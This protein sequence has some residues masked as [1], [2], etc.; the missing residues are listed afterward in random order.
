M[1]KPKICGGCGGTQFDSSGDGSTVC[2]ACGD[3][4]DSSNIVSEIQF[5]ESSGVMGT[6]V[7]ASGSTRSYKNLGRDSRELSIENAR[8]RLFQ[9]A[10]H[11]NL[12]QHHVDMAQRLYALA[13]EHH[14]TKGR[15]TQNIA[16]TCLYIVC[17]REGTPQTIQTN[18]FVLAQTFINFCKILNFQL[19]I[20]DPSL[21]I[22]RFANSLEFEE[23]TQEVAATALK[24]V[25]RMKRDW[26][27][28][29]RRP[30]GICGAALF[31]AAK[32]HG[33]KR[34]TK[35]IVK[36]VKI[37]EDTLVKRLKEFQKTPSAN[38]KV[39]E[40]DVLEIETECD[41]PSF[42]KIRR[43][44]LRTQRKLLDAAKRKHELLHGESMDDD[45][46]E[47]DDQEI[48]TK[49]EGKKRKKKQS[50]KKLKKKKK[51]K[52]E[53]EDEEIEEINDDNVN[54]EQGKEKNVNKIEEEEEEMDPSVKE[55]MEEIGKLISE[56]ENL[57]EKGINK[58]KAAGR[59]PPK[60]RRP[61]KKPETAEEA[62]AEALKR[63]AKQDRIMNL[64]KNILVNTEGDI[65]DEPPSTPMTSTTTTST[66]GRPGAKPPSKLAADT[67]DEEEDDDDKPSGSAKTLTY[68]CFGSGF[69]QPLVPGCLPKSLKTL[70]I[71]SS[72]N[73]PIEI[74]VL[75]ESLTDVTFGSEFDQPLLPMVLPDNLTHLVLKE[76]YNQTLHRGCLPSGLLHLVIGATYC[77][78]LDQGVLPPTLTYLDLGSEFNH[79]LPP[80]VLP[81][82]LVS[83]KLSQQ[84]SCPLEVG[85]L[86]PKLHSLSI[87]GYKKKL[88]SDIFPM[89]LRELKLES[90]FNENLVLPPTI[91][92]LEKIFDFKKS[93]AKLLVPANCSHLTV[94]N[95]FS[96]IQYIPKGVL[97][98]RLSHLDIRNPDL[99]QNILPPS[100]KSLNISVYQIIR[101]GVLP[102]SI[103]SLKLSMQE[104]FQVLVPGS[105]PGSLTRLRF[106]DSFNHSPAI[107]VLPAN[108]TK[109]AFGNSY[110]QPIHPG[111]LPPNLVTLK[112]GYSMDQPLINLPNSLEYL[113]LGECYQQEIDVKLLPTTL[114]LV[115]FSITYS[116]KER[117]RQCLL[118]NMTKLLE[119]NIRVKIIPMS[120]RGPR[121]RNV[122]S[123]QSDSMFKSE[124]Q[125]IL[126]R[127]NDRTLACTFSDDV[128]VFLETTKLG[129]FIKK[130]ARKV[131]LT[132]PG[133]PK[134][135]IWATSSF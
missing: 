65:K 29:G 33:F 37:G 31:I 6:F 127:V 74:G 52:E 36:V 64:F 132:L 71:G 103:T 69:N 123:Q 85:S 60:K 133:M 48:D 38:L 104:E 66:G 12:K 34:T 73:H 14:F 53:D 76:K 42:T 47:D 130:R 61:S 82:S 79:P 4:L 125:F 88:P 3:V 110:N 118:D 40:F 28:T 43:K 106:G 41:P 86:P 72:F 129:D 7:G 1:A 91:T 107:D 62:L 113:Q 80:G 90:M 126:Q 19:P 25:A 99:S 83:L 128:I 77:Q 102:E 109:L 22:H 24:L 63:K 9:I 92:K 35:E 101:P 124:Q 18:V 70:V 32:V 119:N 68:L 81:D 8:R 10:G 78:A 121:L 89:S 96:R 16:A 131:S 95:L 84:Y 20:V 97:P 108:L 135:Q 49:E 116:S 117:D 2:V 15:R 134:P 5:S 11:V 23:K 56:A 93:N 30:S 13:I 59:P 112:Y 58:A 55:G 45:D 115:C 98:S 57:T 114:K 111:T 27:S 39:S 54:V 75:P 50:T 46:I 44:E 51:S 26:M 100:L 17:R 94:N 105:L 67:D 122:P 21:F 87:G 120:I